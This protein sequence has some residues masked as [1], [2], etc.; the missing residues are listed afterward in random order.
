VRNVRRDGIDGLKKLEK[1]GEISQDEQRRIQAE[2]QAL[3]DD[4][5]KKV[6]DA[7]AQKEKEISQV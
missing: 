7:F 1:D 2:I 6:D 5:I 4:Y 3:T